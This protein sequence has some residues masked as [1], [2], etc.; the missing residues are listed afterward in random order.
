MLQPSD[1]LVDDYVETMQ[2]NASESAYKDIMLNFVGS[3]LRSSKNKERGYPN[4]MMLLLFRGGNAHSKI[5]KAVGS[6]APHSAALGTTIRGA[7]G[8]YNYD[9]DGH[10]DYF[11][12]AIV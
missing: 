6:H 3:E 5:S 12:P 10:I 11:Q 8:D 2:S 7:F 4:Y 1:G 9:K